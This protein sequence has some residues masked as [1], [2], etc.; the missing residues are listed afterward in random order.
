MR[1]SVPIPNAT[2]SDHR[3]HEYKQVDPQTIYFL[4][5]QEPYPIDA[6]LNT[7]R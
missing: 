1:G 7:L 3:Y 4:Q 6:V 5:S 2:T